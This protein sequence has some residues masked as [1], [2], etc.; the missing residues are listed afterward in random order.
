MYSLNGYIPKPNVQKYSQFTSTTT[1][2]SGQTQ[3]QRNKSGRKFADKQSDKVSAGDETKRRRVSFVHCSFG[4]P[5]NL[6][7]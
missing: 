7:G 1:A 5:V 4:R 3:F 6:T 2:S